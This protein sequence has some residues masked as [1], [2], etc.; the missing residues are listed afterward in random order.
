MIS[1]ACCFGD[2]LLLFLVRCVLF[3]VCFV[4]YVVRGVLFLVCFVSCGVRWL[5]LGCCWMC[6]I[7]V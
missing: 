1:V 4:W 7:V 6:V 3:A 2:R 5:L